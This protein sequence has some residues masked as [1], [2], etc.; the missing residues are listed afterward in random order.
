MLLSLIGS[1]NT[2]PTPSSSTI[3]SIGS[4]FGLASSFIR[5]PS[6]R[7]VVG[8]NAWS[9]PQNPHHHLRCYR[10]QQGN[11]GQAPQDEAGVVERGY[12]ML[13]SVTLENDHPCGSSPQLGPSAV[14]RRVASC[15]T[16]T[17]QLN[18]GRIVCAPISKGSPTML[19][20]ILER[21]RNI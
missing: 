6:Q 3:F 1:P 10:D 9:S 7:V 16:P 11:A 2:A 5:P 14:S 21:D 8:T 12:A 4:R 18:D 20:E 19:S 13:S 15:A 17:A